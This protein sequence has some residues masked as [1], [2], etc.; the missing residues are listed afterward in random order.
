MKSR[1]TTAFRRHYRALPAPVWDAA[2][3]AYGRFRDDPR[4]PGLQFKR[5]RAGERLVSVR[6]TDD[7]RALGLLSEK[8]AVCFRIGSHQDYD[9]LLR[10]S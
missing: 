9:K 8:G 2:R 10:R 3:R 6:I 5:L 4:H 7:Y 1:V